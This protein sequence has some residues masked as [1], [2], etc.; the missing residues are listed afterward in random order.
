MLITDLEFDSF[1]ECGIGIGY[2]LLLLLQLRCWERVLLLAD[3]L[4]QLAFQGMIMVS[5]G[6]V[7]CWVSIHVVRARRND[8]NGTVERFRA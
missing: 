3:A 5:W 4:L 7:V 2:A 6:A 1:R 8:R